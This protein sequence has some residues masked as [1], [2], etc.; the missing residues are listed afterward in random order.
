M[1]R[2]GELTAELALQIK[3]NSPYRATWI[4]GQATDYLGYL[5]HRNAYVHEGY[6]A[7]TSITPAD[8]GYRLAGRFVRELAQL[9]AGT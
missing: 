6:E 5:N 9:R 8:E 7:Q 2:A 1:R 3:W 4:S